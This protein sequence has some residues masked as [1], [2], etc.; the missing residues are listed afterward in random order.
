[1][2]E[3]P[4]SSENQYKTEITNL[5]DS[6][7]ERIR[8]QVPDGTDVSVVPDHKR[9]DYVNQVVDRSD[10]V[11]YYDY[12]T[13]VLYYSD[14]RPFDFTPYVRQEHDTE[15]VIT[16]MAYSIVQQ[17]VSEELKERGLL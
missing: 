5:A 1:M 9:H 2:V 12:A 14:M 11:D 17:E 13:A 6:V 7:E 3:N 4:I 15:D 8:D 16:G 10:L